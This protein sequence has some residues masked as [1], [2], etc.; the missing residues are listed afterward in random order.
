[1][2]TYASL[3]HI[4]LKTALMSYLYLT[5][6]LPKF[7]DSLP[8]R[9]LCYRWI[10]FEIF[11]TKSAGHTPH[12]KRAQHKSASRRLFHGELS[13]KQAMYIEGSLSDEREMNTLVQST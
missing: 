5:L 12:L 13:A 6:Y 7:E 8:Q 11:Q 2:L 4:S 3:V 10:W 1:M 9:M